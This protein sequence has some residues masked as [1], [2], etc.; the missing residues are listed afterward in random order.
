[1]IDKSDN[2]KGNIENVLGSRARMKILKTLAKNGELSISQVI[3]NTNLNHSCVIKHLD[4][5]QKLSLIQE[6]N[7]GRI[8]ILRFK[9]ENLKAKSFKKFIEIWEGDF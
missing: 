8:K 6:K 7:F 1:M 2:K 9:S 3:K 5:L 4:F